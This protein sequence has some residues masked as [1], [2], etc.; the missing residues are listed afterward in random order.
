MV[1]AVRSIARATGVVPAILSFVSPNCI[2]IKLYTHV[3]FCPDGSMQ[4]AVYF[5]M[6]NQGLFP[7]SCFV[8]GLLFV[9]FPEL[10]LGPEVLDLGVFS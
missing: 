9:L 3:H 2:V 7:L 10:M 1:G 6:L 8:L 4:N 5:G